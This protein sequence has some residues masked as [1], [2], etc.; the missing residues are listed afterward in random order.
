MIQFQN[1]TKKCKCY[2]H[3]YIKIGKFFFIFNMQIFYI[4]DHTR[5]LNFIICICIKLHIHLYFF[6]N[7]H[8]FS[9]YFQ[10]TVNLLIPLRTCALHH[11]PHYHFFKRIFF[12]FLLLNFFFFRIFSLIRLI[13]QNNMHIIIITT[14]M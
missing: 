4:I 2:T 3:P 11:T 9:V 1:S 8:F 10:V 14:I 6:S 12:I 5:I 7:I 13:L